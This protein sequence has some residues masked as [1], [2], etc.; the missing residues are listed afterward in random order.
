MACNNFHIPA[1][2][3]ERKC[4]I[5]EVEVSI[6]Q[7]LCEEDLIKAMPALEAAQAALNTLNKVRY[8]FL[9]RFI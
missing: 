7:K 5:M 3:E 6:K 9:G 2:E 4:Q 1:K 8:L